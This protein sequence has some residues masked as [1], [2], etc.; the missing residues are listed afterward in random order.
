MAYNLRPRNRQK[1]STLQRGTLIIGGA[2]M[3]AVMG[4]MTVVFNAADVED[5]KAQINLM[6]QDPIN[7]GEIILGFSWDEESTIIADAGPSATNVSI[8]A[9]CVPGGID[10]TKGLSAGNALKDINLEIQPTDPLNGDGIDISVWFRKKEDSGNFFTRGKDFNFGMKNGKLIVKYKLTASNGKSYSINEETKYEISDDDLFR[11]YR[12][13]YSPATGKGEILVDQ[14]TV[15]TNQAAENSRLT[16]KTSENIIIGEGM[17]GEGQPVA[18]FDNLIIRKTGQSGN[19]PM[20]L[21][22]FSAELENN[23]T[24]LNWFTGKEN[25]TEYYIIERSD[26]TKTY[27]EIGRVKAAGKSETLKA[28]A[29]V[30]K[31]PMLGITYYR[32]ALS[33]NTSRSIWVPVIAFRLK[34]EQLLNTPTVNSNAANIESS[35]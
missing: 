20:Q 29:L 1:L 18:L 19:S 2:S 14:I 13:I 11:N 16:W 27:K 35:K 5:S 7:N 3:L 6:E 8:F 32:L 28:Y 10:G 17:N 12:F 15:W 33:N 21:L 34:P 31:E 9:E 4:Y 23:Y 22:S 24:M 30:D 26:D 25:G